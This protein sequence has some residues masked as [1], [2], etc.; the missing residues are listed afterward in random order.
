M[1]RSEG[2]AAFLLRPARFVRGRGGSER[3]PV[4]RSR[5]GGPCAFGPLGGAVGPA[6]GAK[7]R[8]F[9]PVGWQGRGG[10]RLR[11]SLAA[12]VLWF[13]GACA[14][15][16]GAGSGP[17]D[18]GEGA[19]IAAA[20]GGRSAAPAGPSWT[21]KL[22]AGNWDFVG[23]ER[24]AFAAEN[25]KGALPA[26]VF[27]PS[28]PDLVRP[29]SGDIYRME[30]YLDGVEPGAPPL[31]RGRPV[32]VHNLAFT[33]APGARL[34]EDGVVE[35]SFATDAP[36]AGGRVDYGVRLQGFGLPQR[37]LRKAVPIE[38][39]P[40]QSPSTPHR[41]W[42]ARIPLTRLLRDK[43]DVEKTRT[44]GRGIL[45]VR[46][47]VLDPRVGAE[48]FDD[49]DVYYRCEPVP[50]RPGS[51]F[52]QLPSFRLGPVVDRVMTDQ[53]TVS[54]ETDVPTVARV[55]VWSDGGSV[56]RFDSRTGGLRHEVPLRGLEP[57][58]AY[59]YLGLVRDGRGE[60]AVATEGAFRTWPPSNDRFR[61]AV[62]SDSRAGLGA[63]DRNF[64]GSNRDALRDLSEWIWARD[65][66]FVVFVGDLINGY[67]TEPGAYRHELAGF[68]RSVQ[69]FASRIP[70][71]EAMGNHELLMAADSH[72]FMV[73]L[74]G[75]VNS[76][77]LFAE[78]FVNP[79]N[80]PKAKPGAPSYRESV[81]SFDRGPV[82]LAV[83]NTNYFFRSHIER[84]DHPHF[85]RGVREGYL[86]DA[87]LAWLDADLT[88]ARQRGATHLFVF[89]H[90]PAFPSAGHVKD[91][92]YWDGRIP[93]VLARR[94]AF[95]STLVKHRVLAAF[96]G[97][98]H[99]YTRTLVDASVRP[100]F[101]VPVWQLVTGG[102][103]AP[104]YAL[105]E[106]VPWRA[107]IRV[108]RPQIHYCEV[109][110]DGDRVDLE[111]VNDRGE[112]IDRVE[113]T[114]RGD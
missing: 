29:F 23:Q 17:A 39:S 63:P 83:L 1:G 58:T 80:G 93:E 41:K 64:R 82:H 56:R 25:E 73:D 105:D 2:A 49:L 54:F 53:A 97:D 38:P 48:R 86:T 22:P 20:R 31:P 33:Q 112:V 10:H 99:S 81:Y 74:P 59:R 70:F 108:Y 114:G 109:Q 111:V 107:A 66:D 15:D 91:A 68:V 42:R 101:D 5:G 7:A 51:R 72:G 16:G 87:Q 34:R 65:N 67:T 84:T 43:Y 24:E 102:A 19:N 12:A 46:V 77:S 27:D 88:A 47:R 32:Q 40:S 75:P 3:S 94:D 103:G 110:V 57:D 55:V 85:G 96:F 113:L 62:M 35:L 14:T 44:E 4:D 90:E 50:C 89:T 52:V 30:S 69:P 45:A 9:G 13:A 106:S 78:V 98:E 37:T 28:G 71:Y 26:P 18:S 95:W 104:Y 76:E 61:F 6:G 8:A 11:A 79:H 36:L 60:V 21:A 92:M 100:A